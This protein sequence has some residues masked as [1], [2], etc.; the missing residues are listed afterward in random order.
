MKKP[1]KLQYTGRDAQPHHQPLLRGTSTGAGLPGHAGT[2][3]W[4][5]YTFTLGPNKFLPVSPSPTDPERDRG[6]FESLQFLGWGV[7]AHH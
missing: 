1:D 6:G 4:G 7:A 2:A 5:E 3:A